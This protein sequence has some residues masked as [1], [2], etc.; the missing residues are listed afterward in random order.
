MYSL[1]TVI[2][3]AVGGAVIGAGAVFVT[4]VVPMERN[5]RK[6]IDDEVLADIA[7][8]REYYEKE[9]ENVVKKKE[10]VDSPEEKDVRPA[11]E[12]S[13]KDLIQGDA[14]EDRTEEEL[15]SIIIE[16]D[17]A[18]VNDEV[19][20]P[21]EGDYHD[22]ETKTG[23]ERIDEEMMIANEWDYTKSFMKYFLPDDVFVDTD[24]VPIENPNHIFG[25]VA[26]DAKH[27]DLIQ[28]VNHDLEMVIE[29]ERYDT[30][31]AEYIYGRRDIKDPL[32]KL[33][34]K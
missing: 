9:R 15:D 33:P 28:V 11:S 1:N 4:V 34:E 6:R 20:S 25:D 19:Y 32:Y 13:S 16:Q 3:S 7:S 17:Y 2:L 14:Q 10:S 27:N 31:Y 23:I 26:D 21:A 30:P 18:V 24:D 5:L 12:D 8:V 22:P 29:V